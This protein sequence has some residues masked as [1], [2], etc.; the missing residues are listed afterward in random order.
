MYLFC[1]SL[2]DALLFGEIRWVLFYAQACTRIYVENI[3]RSL[4]MS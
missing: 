4:K 3:F 1:P 2:M